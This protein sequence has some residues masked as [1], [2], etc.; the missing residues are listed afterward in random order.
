MLEAPTTVRAKLPY[1][2]W[3]LFF[4]GVLTCVAWLG[5]VAL[6]LLRPVIGAAPSWIWNGVAMAL[7]LIPLAV[8][9]GLMRSRRAPRLRHPRRYYALMAAITLVTATP[10]LIPFITAIDLASLPLRQ[11]MLALGVAIAAVDPQVI[12]RWRADR[13]RHSS[14]ALLAGA[15][16]AAATFFIALIATTTSQPTCEGIGC[17][18][19]GAAEIA[20]CGAMLFVMA[21]ALLEV[22]LGY[23]IGALIARADYWWDLPP[24]PRAASRPRLW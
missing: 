1:P 3:L 17:V 24:L 8:V 13:T 15:G 18:L 19:T 5:G 2:G 16:F 11:P 10:A 9:L 20:F 23:V 21:I 7:V 12:E 4:L 6:R 22:W 14:L